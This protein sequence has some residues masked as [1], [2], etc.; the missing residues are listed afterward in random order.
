MEINHASCRVIMAIQIDEILDDKVKNLPTKN[1]MFV[2]QYHRQRF[3]GECVME[4][5]NVNIQ[6]AAYS[7]TNINDLTHRY[8]SVAKKL[9][10]LGINKEPKVYM[11]FGDGLDN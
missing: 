2:F 9:I 3:Y 8:F 6:S 11:I 4:L 5:M 1:G 7:F 10:E